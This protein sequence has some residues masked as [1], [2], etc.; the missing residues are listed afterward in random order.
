MEK[1]E[2]MHTPGPWQQG[3]Y[4]PE[5]FEVQGEHRTLAIVR[6]VF[7]DAVTLANARLIA[8]APE[9]LAAL[10]A[11]VRI[12]PPGS[13][14]SRCHAGIGARADCNRC[15]AIDKAEAVIARAEGREP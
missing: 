3:R 2:S 7:S 4:G 1:R 5:S 13:D 9:L 8:A 6:P 14:D 11:L 10:K 15:S 12:T